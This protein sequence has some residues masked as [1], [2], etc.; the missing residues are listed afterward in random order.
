MDLMPLLP[1]LLSTLPC[2]CFQAENPQVP[3]QSPLPLCKLP[4]TRHRPSAGVFSLQYT[5]DVIQPPS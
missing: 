1:A 3:A 2:L 4:G 5:E